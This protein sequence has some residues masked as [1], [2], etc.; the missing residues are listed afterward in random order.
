MLNEK[1]ILIDYQVFNCS[2]CL[3]DELEPVVN[4]KDTPI[5][6]AYTNNSETSMSAIRYPLVVNYYNYCGHLQLSHHLPT[7]LLYG[8]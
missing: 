7:K 6:D 1:I 8:E 4:L 3:K 5:A 2:I